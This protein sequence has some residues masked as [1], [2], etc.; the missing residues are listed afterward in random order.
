[1]PLFHHARHPF[2]SHPECGG[3]GV[4]VARSIRLRRDRDALL[5]DVAVPMPASIAPFAVAVPAR[6]YSTSC[7]R[8]SGRKR[9]TGLP[10]GGQSRL[11]TEPH[12]DLIAQVRDLT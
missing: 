10:P 8:R 12:F 11:P 7:Q 1:M 5:V 3:A 9:E 2:E 4:V 6:R